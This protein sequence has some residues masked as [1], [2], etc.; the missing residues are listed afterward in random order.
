[1]IGFME[2]VREW[3]PKIETIIITDRNLI[4][5]DE[6]GRAG[7]FRCLT[8]PFN[9]DELGIFVRNAIETRRLKQSIREKR[10]LEIL[11]STGAS[12]LGGCSQS[13]AFELVLEGIRETGFDRV[14][15]ALLS[16]ETGVLVTRS[17]VGIGPT[18]DVEKW[19]ASEDECFS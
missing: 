5:I 3:N 6:A 12:L 17:K 10:S 15:L 19:L 14:R 9:L 1:G 4:E 11:I 8:K 7:A 2:R 13:E 18:L 16:P